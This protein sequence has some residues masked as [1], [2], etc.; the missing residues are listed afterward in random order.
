[1][2]PL[3][4]QLATVA[5]AAAATRPAGPQTTLSPQRWFFRPAS[6]ASPL[7]IAPGDGSSYAT[8]W[9]SVA[10]IQWG[11]I[12]PGDTLFVCGLHDSG[13]VDGF[14]N[15]TNAHGSGR[16]GLP[17][18]V[19]GACVDTD[20]KPDKGT[21][22][23]ATP[24]KQSS[25]GSPD[26]NGIYTFSY[27]TPH[28]APAVR[29]GDSLGMPNRPDVLERS[30][31]DHSQDGHG[32]RRLK[33][34]ECSPTGPTNL[35]LWAPGTACYSGVWTNR[36]TVYYKPTLPGQEMVVYLFPFA[37]PSMINGYPPLSFHNASHIIAQ[38]LTVQGPAW[39]TVGFVGGHHIT[40]RN[41]T[42]RWA[43]FAGVAFGDVPNLRASDE[44][45]YY[46]APWGGPGAQNVTL[47]NN[48]ITQTATGVYM[49]GLGGW[50]TSNDVVVA[51][52]RFM[53]ID[54]ENYYHN[55]DG[56]AI[57]I[58]GGCRNVYEYNIIDGAGGSGITFYQGPDSKDGQPPEPMH[59]NVVRY[60]FIANIVNLD[61]ANQPKNQHGIETGGSRYVQGN[62][63]Y[64]NSVYYNI[65]INVTNIA[66]RSKTLVPGKGHGVYQWRYLN[67]VVVN[68]GVGFSTAYECI[69]AVDKPVCYHPEQVANNVFLHSRTA[70]HDG[71][72]NGRGISH[73]HNDWQNNAYFPDGPEMF[74]YGL[75]A[76]PGQA[77]CKNCT[78]FATFQKDE[79]HPTHSLLADPK[80][81]DMWSLVAAGMRPQT[82][83]PLVNA[84]LDVGLT[85]ATDF[86]GATVPTTPSIGVFQQPA[87]V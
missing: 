19:D 3:L 53:D 61:N 26:S 81:V 35:S 6:S 20:G 77:P 39:E 16:P 43:Q 47:A 29:L 24:Y 58:Q 57:G 23:S 4:V 12:S 36:T 80:L 18:T 22:M 48:L 50:Q 74:C 72:D 85:G 41:C 82:G 21:L 78:N 5:A 69:G 49:V 25:F 17:V 13:R 87:L 68:A 34:G 32:M 33:H 30:I 15:L 65:L 2:V 76:W 54:T 10:D 63:S 46:L 9:T 71:W 27:A 7:S 31:A 45:A 70:H 64:N 62:I 44:S 83:S 1:M 8:A 73:L 28:R 66:L 86:G 51:H 37:M 52:N 40:V 60:N 84:G 56:H 14:L 38:N 59:D 75:C 55:G 67:N 79:P 11:S 42:I